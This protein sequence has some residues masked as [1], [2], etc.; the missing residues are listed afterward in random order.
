[1]PA[2]QVFGHIWNR[3]I[4]P[5]PA[6]FN[7]RTAL[8]TWP[9]ALSILPSVSSFLSPKTFLGFF[10]GTFGLLHQT[11]GP[12]FIHCRILACCLLGVGNGGVDVLFPIA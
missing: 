3:P 12:I 1:M 2:G 6:S 4:L 10:H 5:R 9:A 7:P 11:L 8:C